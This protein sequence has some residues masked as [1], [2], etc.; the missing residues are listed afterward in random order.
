MLDSNVTRTVEISADDVIQAHRDRM[1]DAADLGWAVSQER[2]PVDRGSAGLKG[3]GFAPEWRGE[4]IM[5]GYTADHAEPQE[6]GTRP[7]TPP[8]RPLLEWADRVFSPERTA[9]EVLADLDEN[10]WHPG[11]FAHPGAGVW[12]K[13]RSEG[14][15]PN[16]YLAPAADRMDGYLKTHGL[17]L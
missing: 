5:F 7:Y 17:D 3:S 10:G 13:I 1:E 4:T 8:L 6:D 15:S 2:V 14:L 11:I 16:P 12:S 9:D